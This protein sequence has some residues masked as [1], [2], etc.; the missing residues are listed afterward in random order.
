MDRSL[1]GSAVEVESHAVNF[2]RS[3]RRVLPAGKQ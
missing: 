2:E 3:F 1:E